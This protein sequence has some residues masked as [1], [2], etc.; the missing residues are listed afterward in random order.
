MYRTQ[1]ID[2][3]SNATNAIR[4]IALGAAAAKPAAAKPMISVAGA[5]QNELLRALSRT[6]LEA[7]FPH[8][9]LVPMAAGKHLYDFGSKF[10]Y[11]YFPT[12]AIVSLM[13]VMEDGAT[14]EIGV[15]G[16]EGVL[17]VAM[18][19][20]ERATCSAVV[21]TAGYAYR[22]KSSVLRELV[23]SGGAM[24]QLLMRYTFAMFAQLAQNVVGGRHCTIEQKLCR[25]LLDRLDRSL[26]DEIKVT[27]DTMATMLGVRRETIT[28]TARKLQAD[29]LIQYRRGTVAII[30]RAGLEE[31]AGTCYR[32]G[33]IGFEQ[34]HATAWSNA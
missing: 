22:L 16:R 34:M 10:D 2:S 23:A 13:Y 3:N 21:Q 9:E 1:N 19:E 14:T 17:G 20:A 4:T 26:S 6:D 24:A 18:Y 8:L 7:L 5:Q 25:W 28:M 27:Q 30:D 33:K 11:A 29:G 32:A 31:C 12:N 15:V